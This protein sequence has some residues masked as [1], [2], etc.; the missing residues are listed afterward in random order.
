[1]LQAETVL[2]DVQIET[3]LEKLVE[4][5]S[6][7]GFRGAFVELWVF[8]G[9]ERRSRAAEVL[10]TRGVRAR[11]HAAYK[12]LV[13]A[14]NEELDR[15]DIDSVTIRYPVVEGISKTR[16]LLEC[17]PVDILFKDVRLNFEPRKPVDGH[18]LIHYQLD[19][20]RSDGSR[21]LLEVGAPNVFRADHIGCSIYSA[22]GWI[23][24]RFPGD[25]H[26]DRD[27]PF[28]TDQEFAFKAAMDALSGQNWSGGGPYFDRLN[29][30][31]EA[32]FYDDR[33]NDGNERLSTAE[34]MH[35]DL[36]FSALEVFRKCEGL[37]LE[38]R[39]LTPGQLV[40]QIVPQEGPLRV[41]LSAAAGREPAFPAEPAVPERLED[42]EHW[43]R[44]SAVKAHL[45]RVG[46]EFIETDSRRGRPIW[47]SY[48]DGPGPQVVITAGQ[49]AN[50]TT[51]PV[52]ALRAAQE[53][54]KSGKN[55]FF[56]SPLVN[57]DGFALFRELCGAYPEHMNHAARYTAAGCDLEYTSRGFENEAH[58]IGR[59]KTKSWLHLNLHGYPSHEWTRP[60]SGY[61]PR[62]VEMWTIPKGFFLI[63]RYWKGWKEQ[64]ERI[65]HAI[66]DELA[67]YQPII[68]LNSEQL[69]RYRQY[70]ETPPFFVR[71][72]VPYVSNE[73][74]HGLFPVTIITEAPDETIYGSEFTINHTAQMISV[75][76]AAKAN[77]NLD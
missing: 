56:V 42:V 18:Q 49:H 25:E 46:G 39:T 68:D 17:Y 47:S 57:P 11:V 37:D 67:G 36:Y 1:M 12:P 27:E 65:L 44:P 52:G 29:M 69:Q 66:I 38:D 77:V 62:G 75:L 3:S 9:L 31:V 28:R 74:A 14:V 55:G 76:A 50:E 45:E 63:L 26:F 61:V 34:A 23:R 6:S 48:V 16:F 10:N 70:T 15:S 24:V 33:L 32:P 72:N 58:H 4:T 8:D 51:G 41:R 73:F 43:L 59:E 71:S 64:G 22:A 19:V 53:M 7:P 21:E 30:R 54:A 40:P 60:Y 35:E 2:C 13:H 5:F 20:V